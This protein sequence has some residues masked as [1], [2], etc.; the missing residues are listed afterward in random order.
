MTLKQFYKVNS[1]IR[2]EYRL[3]R[4]GKYLDSFEVDFLADMDKLSGMLRKFKEYESATV[5]HVTVNPCNGM[6]TVSLNIR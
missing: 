3:L 6:L 1:E 2:T 5:Q 4:N